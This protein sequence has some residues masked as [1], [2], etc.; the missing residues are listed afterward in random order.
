MVVGHRSPSSW[1][2]LILGAEGLAKA[3][4]A[5][6]T[7]AVMIIEPECGRCD[8]R[9][10]RERSVHH[11]GTHDYPWVKV[12]DPRCRH[13]GECIRTADT[14][15]QASV[16]LQVVMGLIGLRSTGWQAVANEFLLQ[17]G[18]LKSILAYLDDHRCVQVPEFFVIGFASQVGLIQPCYLVKVRYGY[19][20]SIRSDMDPKRYGTS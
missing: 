7:A 15:A 2:L 8:T 17:H 1:E 10:D 4:L 13:S 12:F 9:T 6:S 20:H 18:L 5:F 3:C 14:V 16:D 11:D 19:E